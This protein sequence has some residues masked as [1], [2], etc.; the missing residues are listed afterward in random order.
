MRWVGWAVS[1]GRP[2]SCEECRMV[3]KANR[4]QPDC[5]SCKSPEPLSERNRQA[6]N[7]W[8][9]LDV[10][11][12]PYDTMSGNP[13]PLRL[14]AVEIEC[15]KHGDPEGLRWRLLLIDKMII[16][17]RRDKLETERKRKK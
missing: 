16:D 17:V 11:G 13:L 12:R 8:A 2:T 4:R 14:E 5:G 9:T 15:G 10:H 3:A 7:A 1:P 6:W